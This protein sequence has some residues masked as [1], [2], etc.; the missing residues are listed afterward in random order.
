MSNFIPDG[1]CI[2]G[3]ESTSSPANEQSTGI[4]SLFDHTVYNDRLLIAF[5]RRE[6]CLEVSSDQN[7]KA[8]IPNVVKGV[9]SSA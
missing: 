6:V 7:S 1:C 2:K 8:M 4:M 5:G 3:L 9:L